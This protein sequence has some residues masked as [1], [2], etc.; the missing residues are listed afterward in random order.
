MYITDLRHL[1]DPKGAIGPTKGPARA[2]AKFLADA[3]AHATAGAGQVPDA[4]TC[5]KCRNSAVQATL[6]RD[7]AVVWNCPRCE[8]EGQ[9]S[10]WQRTLWNLR[11]RPAPLA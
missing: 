3:V 1:L 10:N 8:T 6:G 11:D 9:I 4:P 7:D 2:M 5:F